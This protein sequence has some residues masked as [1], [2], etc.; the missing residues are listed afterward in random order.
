MLRANVT[1]KNAQIN[2][3]SS[4]SRSEIM[5]SPGCRPGSLRDI[6]IEETH[7][8]PSE[9]GC[10]LAVS[11]KAR[12]SRCKAMLCFPGLEISVRGSV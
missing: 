9:L 1:Q 3:T 6:N 5:D 4:E 2:L 8:F 11:R 10:F 7:P 12:T